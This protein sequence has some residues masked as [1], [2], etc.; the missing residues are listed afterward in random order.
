AVLGGRAGL[1]AL[2]YGSRE[3]LRQRLDRRAVA[4][5]L[6]PLARGGPHPLFLLLDVRHG[7]K[8]PAERARRWYQSD[9][10]ALRGRLAPFL[11]SRAWTR[12]TRAG[13]SPGRPRSS[14]SRRGSRASSGSSARSSPP[15]T[16]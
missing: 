15:T 1:V 14:R 7:V 2:V 4:E 8:R 11:Y 13:G 6:E 16:S 10:A 9:R 5:V 3:A 12:G